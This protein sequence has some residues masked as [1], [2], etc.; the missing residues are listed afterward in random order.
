MKILKSTLILLLLTSVFSLT[1]NAQNI[2]R[3][4]IEEFTNASCGPCASQNPDFKILLDA[5]E[6]EVVAIKWQTEFPGYD[7][8]YDHIPTEIDVRTD[9][10][11][12]ISGVPTAAMNGIVPK[13]TYAGGIG[14][15]QADYAGGPY[16]YNQAVIDNEE[17]KRLSKLL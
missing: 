12:D 14:T 6:T 10:Y 11:P 5:N 1:T 2:K 15:W 8:M 9:Y 3:V 16:G 13:D 17:I 7:P 4:L